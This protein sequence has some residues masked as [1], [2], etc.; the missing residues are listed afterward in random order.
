MTG[1]KR[2]ATAA[3]AVL[4]LIGGPAGA[5]TYGQLDCK[6]NATNTG[7]AHPSTVSLSGFRLKGG[8][9]VSSVRCSGSLLS[10]EEDWLVVLTAGHC[11]AAY[12]DGLQS[13]ALTAVGV[14][15]DAQI[16]RLDPLRSVWPP[17][18]YILG[19]APVLPR[20]Y[21]PH[22][23]NAFNLQFDY[24][25][26]VFRRG[27]DAWRT[28]EGTLV[29]VPS[30]VT[31]APPGF[32]ETIVNRFQ[33]PAT[34]TAVGYGTGE[35]HNKPGEGGNKGG[36]VNDP[37]KLGVRWRTNL[38]RAFSYLGKNANLLLA[39]QNPARGDEGA[40]GGDSGGPL[41]HGSPE[42]QVGVTS[43][44]DSIC[45]ATSIIARTDGAEATAFLGCVKGA[46]T[47]AKVATCGCTEVTSKGLCAP[48]P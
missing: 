27:G 33:P 40:C 5:I 3:V 2:L 43:S 22:G 20:E 46:S 7:C 24:G 9:L 36:V 13:G 15:F 32:V 10:K 37:D 17:D 6:D 26:I 39:S 30:P 28:Y 18:Q 12:L 4:V 16:R 42:R 29:A 14:S 38:T 19:G 35:A 25:V 47:P 11:V 41:F 1:S 31:L 34:L 23:L 21:G 45:R 44:G 8:R 48:T